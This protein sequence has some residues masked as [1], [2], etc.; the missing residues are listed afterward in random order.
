MEK[1]YWS[2]YFDFVATSHAMP[3]STAKSANAI[4]VFGFH[5]F[6]AALL[7]FAL[8]AWKG[9]DF[10]SSGISVTPLVDDVGCPI[11]TSWSEDVGVL[12]VSAASGAPDVASAAGEWVEAL[13]WAT[14]ALALS[15]GASLFSSVGSTQRVAGGT[16][17]F[18]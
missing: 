15:L 7:F 14:G 6:F 12:A 2:A 3:V 4:N 18:T 10:P 5:R 1:G 9:S 16:S 13:V 17:A 8:C 11:L